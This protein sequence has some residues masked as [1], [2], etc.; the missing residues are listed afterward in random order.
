MCAHM[1]C[2]V[3]CPRLARS[4]R[5]AQTAQPRSENQPLN[6]VLCLW[7]RGGVTL[8]VCLQSALHWRAAWNFPDNAVECV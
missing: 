7:I 6:V 5:I 2:Y 3:C 8:G 1:C 4:T